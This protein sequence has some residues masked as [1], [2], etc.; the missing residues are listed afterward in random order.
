MWH[1]MSTNLSAAISTVLSQNPTLPIPSTPEDLYVFFPDGENWP[2][3]DPKVAGSGAGFN[4]QITCGIALEFK[5][6]IFLTS[7]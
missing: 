2:V 6:N 4:L 3:A 7:V 1:P 5:S